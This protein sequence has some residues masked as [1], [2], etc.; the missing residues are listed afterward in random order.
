M[1]TADFCVVCRHKFCDVN[2]SYAK[3]TED[4]SHAQLCNNCCFQIK[5]EGKD[6]ADGV[7]TVD[8][9][10]FVAVGGVGSADPHAPQHDKHG[11]HGNAHHHHHHTAEE[12][13]KK[14]LEA[15]HN[16]RHKSHAH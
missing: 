2:P 15:S 6:Y 4:D 14:K 13:E 11:H 7:F 9:A 5:T 12:M 10:T 3:T 16:E 8:D 1:S